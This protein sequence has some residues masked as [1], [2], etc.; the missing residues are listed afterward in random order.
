MG[1]K[2]YTQRLLTYEFQVSD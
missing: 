1:K 2:P